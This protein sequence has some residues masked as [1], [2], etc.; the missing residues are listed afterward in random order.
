FSLVCLLLLTF[1]PL[2]VGTGLFL[3]G[4]VLYAA[5]LA[6]LIVAVLNFRR[7]PLGQ[8][9]TRGLYAV[10]RHPQIVALFF[11]FLGMSLA[12]GS[13]SALVALL[14]SRLL[15]HPAILAE[16]EACLEQYGDSYREYMEQV[17]RYLLF[18]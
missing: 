6:G 4:M 1:T 2:Q 10:S 17:P 8:P 15:Q 18:I 11:A 3:V 16:E 12:V 13:W 9:V 14:I 7:T 5:G